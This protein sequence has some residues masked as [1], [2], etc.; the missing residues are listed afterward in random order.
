MIV[1]A[2]MRFC[3]VGATHSAHKR[4]TELVPVRVIEYC[5]ARFFDRLQPTIPILTLDY[6]ARLKTSASSS[7]NEKGTES[8]CVLVGMCGQV[9]L[10]TEEP[11]DLFHQGIIPERNLDF[12][13]LLLETIL[14]TYHTL[15][16]H[17]S[18]SV[19]LCLLAFFIYACEAVLFHH[20]RAFWFLR[21][22]TTLLLLFRPEETDDLGRLVAS[23][24]FWVLL[25]SE[26]SHAIRYRRPITLQIT[27]VTPSL[28]T[29]DPALVGF[30][31]LAALFRPI[32][33]S[34][35]A[36][37]NHE[38]IAIGPTP[39][40]IN[41][42][43][44]KVN[45]A[46]APG[47]VLRDTQKTNLRVTQFW[48]RVIIWQLR[49]HLGYLVE[50]SY[51]HNLTFR[52]PIEVTKDLV[53][54]TRDLAIESFKVHGVGLTEKLFDIASALVDVLARIPVTPTSPRGVATGTSPEDDLTYLR[55][56][57]RKLPGGN[58]IYNDLLEEHIQ[59]TVPGLA[60]PGRDVLSVGGLDSL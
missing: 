26:R 1:A 48:L 16:R 13:Q 24:L 36:L 5:T 15:P 50:E 19:E 42:V 57:I 32:D 43:E 56:M 9:L 4:L 44:A 8:L 45:S 17:S 38:N 14:S 20:S 58:T 12:G 51:Q 40:A 2:P 23:R 30:W 46:L 35:I 18:V 10:Q 55:D 3:A 39:E 41:H 28:D 31:S 7:A 60:S 22:T 29:N 59:Q 34:F 52:Y 11:E 6:V 21:E 53:L 49:L 27:D 47:I 33:T 37:F 54:S 25:I